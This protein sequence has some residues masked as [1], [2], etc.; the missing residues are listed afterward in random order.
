M[1]GWTCNWDKGEGQSCV[2]GVNLQLGQRVGDKLCVKGGVATKTRF[3][4]SCVSGVDLQPSRG[5]KAS[6]VSRVDLQLGRG[7]GASYMSRAHLQ[8]GRGSGKV[9]YRGH[10]RN[11]NKDKKWGRGWRV[12]C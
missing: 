1:S 11:Y 8:L 7:S 3:E 12:A 5:L 2:S 6:C 10:T 4:T 9:V